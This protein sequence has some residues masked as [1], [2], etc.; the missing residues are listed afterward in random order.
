MDN[1]YV[2]VQEQFPEFVQSDYPVFVQFV[3]AYYKWLD[4]Q[5]IGRIEDVVD[6]DNTPEQFVTYF[7][8]QLDVYGLFN[9]STFDKRYIKKIKQIYDSKGSEQSLINILRLVYQ[10]T[11]TVSYP[12]KNILR[13]SDGRWVQEKFITVETFYG[14]VPSTISEFVISYN[15]TSQRILVSRWEA[16]SPTQVR[17]YYISYA[18][19]LIDVGQTISVYDGA[20]VMYAGRVVKSPAYITVTKG[21]LNWQLGQV[22]VFP[23]TIKDTIGRV[24]AVGDG[25]SI[26]RVEILEFGYNHTDGGSVIVSPYPNKP[27]AS[28]YELNSYQIST[29]P[30]AYQYDLTLY[31]YTD[32]TT[33]NITGSQYHG[34]TLTTSTVIDQ[35]TTDVS[36]GITIPSSITM[37]EWLASRATLTINH[38]AVVSTKGRWSD[39]SGQISNESIRIEDNF[40][41]Q[42]FSYNIEADINSSQYIQLAKTVHP[43]GMK[44]FT[45]YSLLEDINI[46]PTALTSFPFIKTYLLDVITLA[47]VAS[48]HQSKH[49]AESIHSLSDAVV[50]NVNKYVDESVTVSSPDTSTFTTIQYNAEDYFAENY[51]R[52]EQFLVLGA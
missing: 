36:S 35:T 22:V 43:A 5:G 30:V 28:T 34:A 50:L 32:S 42:Q 39:D 17:L 11:A 18:N 1:L 26:T 3:Q 19:I 46:T 21:G 29:D 25:G 31:D 45:T 8:T 2:L 41:Y 44:L 40:Y 7:R 10:T 37:E 14:S 47:D 33:E 27:L 16:V 15:F 49:F 4:Q 24:A 12:S 9:D 20:A 48:K 51:V 38:S 6:I 52:L 23:G 13:S